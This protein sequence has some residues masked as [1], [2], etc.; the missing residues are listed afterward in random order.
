MICPVVNG[1]RKARHS[2]WKGTCLQKFDGVGGTGS[3]LAK[4]I[5]DDLKKHDGVEGTSL[6]QMQGTVTDGQY[7]KK[8]YTTAMD[9]PIFDVLKSMCTSDDYKIVAEIKW[10]KCQCDSAH[11]LDKVF[12]KLKDRKIVSQL[13]K[14]QSRFL[15]RFSAME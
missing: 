11:W 14:L 5:Y 7:I 1:V 9:E 10:W 4:A 6:L 12:A 3:E 13:L 2:A 15:I 8:P